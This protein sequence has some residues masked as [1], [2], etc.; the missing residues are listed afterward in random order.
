MFNLR[1]VKI[2]EKREYPLLTVSKKAQAQV[3]HGAK[4]IYGTEITDINGKPQN[5]D[6]VDIASQKGS[7][8]GTGLYSKTSKIAV[9][10]LTRNF[11][12]KPGPEF[13]R[14]RVTYA[15]D[16]RR[17]VMPDD[18][19]CCR[20]IFGEA[21][22]F[23]GLTVDK[24]GHILVAQTLCAGIEKSKEQIFLALE[25][26]L[27]ESGHEIEGIYE[28][29]DSVLR[30]NEGLTQRKGW[31][32]GLPH[33]DKTSTQICENGILYS[34]DFENGQKTGYFLD[35]KYNRRAVGKLS[36]DMNV[37]DCFTHTGSFA[38]NAVMGGARSVTAV[39]ISEE[40][41]KTARLNASLNG[42]E[43]KI[44]FIASDVFDL[45]PK[46]TEEGKGRYDLIIL[47]PPAFTKSRAT[48]DEARR[49]YREINCR[50]MKLLPRGGYL[51]T[52]SCSR[53]ME[54]DMFV[55]MLY[56]ASYDAD[57]ELKRIEARYQGPD[58]PVLMNMPETEYL[59]FY[60]FQVI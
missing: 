40:A 16:Y 29:N 37:L 35:Q 26:V 14:R 4:W 46:L 30:E 27:A 22:G 11:N 31:Y 44:Q 15:W 9:R 54:D 50:A 45:L 51:A 18:L 6:I 24:F 20:V 34:V 1:L 49:G 39:D 3:V 21:D 58:H 25:K 57:V 41:L 55:K 43:E 47:D 52:C 19:D 10:L 2:M 12:D 7:Y 13:Y 28:R 53:F 59:K 32:E 23:P 5:G 38:L 8:L 56:E 36:K 42:C 33:P 17:R 60:I 48:V